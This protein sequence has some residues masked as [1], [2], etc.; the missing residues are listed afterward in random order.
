V[1]GPGSRLR[2]WVRGVVLV[3]APIVV[4]ALFAAATYTPLF[5]LQTLRSRGRPS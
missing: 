5:G 2:P 1:I 4:V 3:A